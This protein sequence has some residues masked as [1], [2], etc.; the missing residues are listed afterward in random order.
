V[1]YWPFREEQLPMFDTIAREVIP[2]LKG[3]YNK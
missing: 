2:E 3:K 1:L